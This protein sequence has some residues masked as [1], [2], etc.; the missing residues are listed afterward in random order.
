[1]CTW[2]SRHDAEGEASLEHAPRSQGRQDKA[3]ASV[4]ERVMQ[5]RL[6]SCRQRVPSIAVEENFYAN[7]SSGDSS[8][9]DDDRV[10]DYSGTQ[11]MRR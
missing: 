4:L 6:F 3:T 9:S 10:Y 8:L 1:M 7:D 11:I 2:V 5:V